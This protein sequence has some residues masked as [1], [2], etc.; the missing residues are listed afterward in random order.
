MLALVSSCSRYDGSKGQQ[1]KSSQKHWSSIKAAAMTA[2]ARKSAATAVNTIAT[3]AHTKSNIKVN[4]AANSKSTLV[5]NAR[6]SLHPDLE[7]KRD[8]SETKSMSTSSDKGIRA[9][10]DG[11]SLHY[12][13]M[14]GLTSS[15]REFLA[16]HE[17]RASIK[18]LPNVL[19]I[20]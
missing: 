2:T 3:K 17:L 10:I 4:S 15:W 5:S 7:S 12:I 9:G 16:L 14:D 18:L 6:H 1:V 19:G 11:I 8:V 13:L 20:L